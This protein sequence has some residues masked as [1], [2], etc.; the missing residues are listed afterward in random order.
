MLYL[1]DANILIDADRDYYPIG[2]VPEFWGWL[3]SLANNQNVKIPREIYEKVMRGKKSRT[4]EGE[5]EL[6]NWLKKR[7]DTMVLDENI[8]RE[9]IDRVVKCY[10]PNLDDEEIGVLGRDPFLIAYAL[11]HPKER[12]IITN[13]TS[14]PKRRRANR[15]IPDVCKDLGV[16]C[17]N[18]FKFIRELNFRTDWQSAN[19]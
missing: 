12:I 2:R 17:C 8:D 15:H 19:H 9:L 16:H 5:E 10:A 13:E 18:T 4:T 14:K 11:Q 6:P 1:L 7:E 3:F